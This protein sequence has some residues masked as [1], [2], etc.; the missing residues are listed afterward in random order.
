[1]TAEQVK[2]GRSRRMI[3]ILGLTLLT[4]I[5]GYAYYSTQRFLAE[6]GENVKIT[7]QVVAR[8]LVV[9]AVE[10]LKKTVDKYRGG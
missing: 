1:M 7:P 4:S 9:I 6:Q 2:P 5:A 8:E 10:F 3:L